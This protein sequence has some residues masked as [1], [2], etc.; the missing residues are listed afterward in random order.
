M[1]RRGGAF[2]GLLLSLAATPASQPAVHAYLE[3]Q[4]SI[5]Q[6][7]HDIMGGGSAPLRATVLLEGGKREGKVGNL[8]SCSPPLPR[9]LW[10]N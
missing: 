1:A 9:P 8:S 3:T 6:F 5:G 2:T 4:D 7:L 10:S